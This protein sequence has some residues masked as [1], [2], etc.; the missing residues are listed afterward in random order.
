VARDAHVVDLALLLQQL[1][2]H[3]GFAAIP[4]ITSI[5]SSSSSRTS[6]TVLYRCTAWDRIEGDPLIIRQDSSANLS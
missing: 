6:S 2:K 4:Q 3:R 1:L 5:S